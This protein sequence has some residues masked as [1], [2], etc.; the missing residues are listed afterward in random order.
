VLRHLLVVIGSGL[1]VGTALS[2]WLSHYVAP[3]LYGV[4]AR[5]PAALAA[6]AATL[7]SVGLASAWLPARRA[8]RADPAIVLR[9]N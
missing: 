8:A 3:L 5:S 7:A 4:Q 9:E 2:V 1:A 6:A